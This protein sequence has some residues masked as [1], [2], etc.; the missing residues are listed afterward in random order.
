M[1]EWADVFFTGRFSPETVIISNPGRVR[2]GVS[3]KI[4][5]SSHQYKHSQPCMLVITEDTFAV[6]EEES[7]YC[8]TNV[9]FLT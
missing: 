8:D 7:N 6:K 4:C 3:S 1:L 5:V 2:F 9:G